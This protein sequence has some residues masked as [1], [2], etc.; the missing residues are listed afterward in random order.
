LLEER[1]RAQILTV[2]RQHVER[3]E[4]RLFTSKQQ[5]IKFRPSVGRQRDDLPVEDRRMRAT[6]WAS[7]V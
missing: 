6:A 1:P 2:D 7:S 3:H 5:V 4:V